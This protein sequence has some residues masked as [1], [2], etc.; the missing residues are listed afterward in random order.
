MVSAVYVCMH[1]N[2]EDGILDLKYSF[3][4]VLI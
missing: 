1:V 4:Y 3:P 2:I